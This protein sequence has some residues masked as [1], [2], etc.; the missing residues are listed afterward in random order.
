MLSDWVWD[1]YNS[2]VERCDVGAQLAW[3]HM[4]YHYFLFKGG[5]T[6]V[7]TPSALVAWA[8]YS[9]SRGILDPKP[10]LEEYALGDWQFFVDN[11][12]R[13][14]DGTEQ[15]NLFIDIGHPDFL[16]SLD[17]IGNAIWGALTQKEFGYLLSDWMI[18][19]ASHQ[20][21]NTDRGDDIM[22]QVGIDAF[23][24]YGDDLTLEWLEYAMRQSVDALQAAA[25][26]PLT[27][28]NSGSN[29]IVPRHLVN[30]VAL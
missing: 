4:A 25:T 2:S 23:D 6:G 29:K 8:A 24:R 19:E 16:F 15:T 5:F 17:T 26:L 13:R 11:T 18:L 12:T 7:N 10:T 20:A 3:A 9:R 28:H 14:S 27:V 30:H 1:G 21:G 22:V